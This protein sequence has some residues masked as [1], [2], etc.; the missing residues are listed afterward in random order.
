M[1]AYLKPF[2]CEDKEIT[3]DDKVIYF[4]VTDHLLK[5]LPDEDQAA[6]KAQEGKIFKVISF[7]NYGYAEIEFE[8]KDQR[9]T[10]WV[11]PKCLKKI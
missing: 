7:D 5:N 8:Q 2:D 6:I 10:M 3:V 9:H 11:E 1:D 4:K